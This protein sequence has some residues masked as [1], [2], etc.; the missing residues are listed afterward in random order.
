MK[1]FLLF[2][3]LVLWCGALLAVRFVR[4]QNYNYIFLAWN[5]FLAIIPAVAAMLMTRA[6]SAQIPLFI[7]WLAFLP[8]AP[9]IVTDFVHLTPQPPV[10][11]WYDVALLISFAETGLLLAYSS[12]ADVQHVISDRFNAVT[13]WCVAIAS[14]LLSGLG[15]YMGR[16]L[17]WNS[18]DPLANP[19]RVAGAIVQHGINPLEHP[20][21]LA[22]TA[23]YGVGLALGYIGLRLIAPA[24]SS[25]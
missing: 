22:V 16:F 21:P 17:R 8:N 7:I 1:R 11:L 10:P 18:W 13:G 20:R 23:I 4:A 2:T 5:L 3:A 24:A 12:V 14:L 6:K 25:R 19:R 9:Y 15:I